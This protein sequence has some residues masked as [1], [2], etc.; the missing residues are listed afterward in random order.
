[1]SLYVLLAACTLLELSSATLQCS[2]WKNVL[3]LM[4]DITEF[5]IL[6]CNTLWEH[7]THC[8]HTAALSSSCCFPCFLPHGMWKLHQSQARW[9]SFWVVCV[10]HQG[11]YGGSRALLF[12]LRARCP[13]RRG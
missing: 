8:K 3:P 12:H 9:E 6:H 1:M 2:T 11:A 4:K 13:G 10:L 5:C 7:L